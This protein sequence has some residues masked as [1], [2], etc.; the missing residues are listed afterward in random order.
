MSREASQIEDISPNL[1]EQPREKGFAFATFLVIVGLILS[2]STG[3]I[4]E[5]LV[6]SKFSSDLQEAFA[7][8]FLIPDFVYQ[9]LVGGAIQAAIT[10]SLAR[11]LQLGDEKRGLRSASIF[12]SIAAVVM[13]I[14]VIA[15]ILLSETVYPLFFS[16]PEK[17]ETVM[18][19]AKAARILFPQIFF[20]MLAAFSIG[21]LNAY[22]KFTATSMGPAVYNIFVL[23]AIILWGGPSDSALYRTIIG[24]MIAALLYFLFQLAVGNKYLRKFHF[25]LHTHDSGF[26]SLF[27]LAIPILVSSA[28]IQLN[29]III[30]WFANYLPENL[31]FPIRNAVTLWQLPYGIFAVGVGTVMLPSLAGHFAAG[32]SQLASNLLSSSL[33]NALFMTIPMTGFLIMMPTDII[34]AVFRWNSNYSAERILNTSHLLLGYSA[35]VIIHTVIFI[36]NQ[37]YYAI[38]KTKMPLFSGLISLVVVLAGNFVLIIVNPNSNPIYLTLSYSLAS[39]ISALFLVLNYRQYRDLVPTGILSF[40]IKAAICLLSLVVV[41]FFMNRFDYSPTGK[42]TEILLVTVKGTVGLI[43]YLS[44]AA[45]L[46]MPELQSFV[47]RVQRRFLRKQLPDE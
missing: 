12:I 22:K 24:I 31:Q 45:L 47:R 13:G 16:N 6:S 44:C 20:M 37:A 34:A 28:I 3:F 2:R 39:L 11:S 15:G 40:S 5:M 8:A 9:L 41:L 1:S 23:L 19:A 4:R 10:P 7:L 29:T 26:R 18:I 30:S 38:G 27:R 43:V 17:L 42:M 21:I 46:K 36:Y 33:R 14:T 32:K 35:A 25:S